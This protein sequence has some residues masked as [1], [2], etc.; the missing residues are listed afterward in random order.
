MNVGGVVRDMN[1][2][3]VVRDMNVGGVV[4]RMMG[5]RPFAVLRVTNNR[6]DVS[7]LCSRWAGNRKG[8]PYNEGNRTKH[9]KT[10]D[11]FTPF[12]KMSPNN[13]MR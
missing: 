5:V 9:K 1:V 3:G 7:C 2:G 8:Y 6:Q 11:K 12:K 13:Y 10:F 4:R